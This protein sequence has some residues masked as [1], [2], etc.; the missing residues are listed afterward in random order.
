MKLRWVRDTRKGVKSAVVNKTLAGDEYTIWPVCHTYLVEKGLQ[1]LT[2]A[3]AR[4]AA[5]GGAVLLDVRLRDSYDAEH[6]A[7]AL[8]APLFR[9]IEGGREGTAGFFD[10][11]KKIAMGG[12]A[13]VRGG[14]PASRRTR[15][16]A[17]VRARVT[18]P[19]ERAN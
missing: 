18:F 19:G 2:P 12:F 16:P 8:N 7:G 6:A 5:G 4:E 9:D 10:Q 1:S 15:G 3:E 14:L 11:V 17:R 13:M